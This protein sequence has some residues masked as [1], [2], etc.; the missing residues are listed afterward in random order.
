M[1]Y[2]EAPWERFH[3]QVKALFEKDDDIFVSDIYEGSDDSEIDYGFDIEV[4][5][6]DKYLALDRLLPAVKTFGLVTL[7]ITLYDDGNDPVDRAELFRTL[8]RSNPICESVVTKT[9][10]ADTPWTYVVFKPEVIQFFDDNLGDVNGNWSGLA[11]DIAPEI[12]E[13]NDVGVFF[14]TGKANG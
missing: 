8:F 10:P 14:C 13:G 1:M 9:D 6:H 3:K 5:D 12:F 11:E 4:R 2:L 7:A